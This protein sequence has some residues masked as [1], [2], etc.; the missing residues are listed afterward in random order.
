MAKN[1]LY[2]TGIEKFGNAASDA[3]RRWIKRAEAWSKAEDVFLKH[4]ITNKKP[5]SYIPSI[6]STATSTGFWGVWMTVFENEQPVKEA[7]IQAFVGTFSLCEIT[8]IDRK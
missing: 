2:L 5:A 6:V 8:N 7:L 1:T 4:Y 3:D